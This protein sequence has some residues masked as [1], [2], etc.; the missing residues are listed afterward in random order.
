M[1]TKLDNQMEL[2]KERLKRRRQLS[3]SKKTLSRNSLSKNPRTSFTKKSSKTKTKEEGEQVSAGRLLK[4]ILEVK[5]EENE[6]LLKRSLLILKNQNQEI[7]KSSNQHITEKNMIYNPDHQANLISQSQQLDILL[8]SELIEEKDN[9]LGSLAGSHT[10]STFMGSENTINVGNQFLQNIE[11]GTKECITQ[12]ESNLDSSEMS[13]GDDEKDDF[14]ETFEQVHA[15]NSLGGDRS[16]NG[17]NIAYQYKTE[18]MNGEA[19]DQINNNLKKSGFKEFLDEQ[20]LSPKNVNF[21]ASDKSEGSD[22]ETPIQKEERSS[23]R[24]VTTDIQIED[25]PDDYLSEQRPVVDLLE[26]DVPLEEFGQEDNLMSAI[27]M[28]ES[29]MDNNFND[30]DGSDHSDETDLY[31]SDLSVEQNNLSNILKKDKV[32]VKT[33]TDLAEDSKLINPLNIKNKNLTSMFV[34]SNWN[35][36]AEEGKTFEEV[37]DENQIFISNI[38]QNQNALI[39]H[40]ITEPVIPGFGLTIINKNLQDSL[41]TYENLSKEKLLD[42]KETEEYKNNFLENNFQSEYSIGMSYDESEQV[43]KQI[44]EIEKQIEYSQHR[45]SQL[46]KDEVIFS[47]VEKEELSKNLDKDE[48]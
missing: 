42:P 29:I 45:L 41:T 46:Q 25:N 8:Q 30:D 10:P 19:E 24:F 47:N 7:M 21:L 16:H 1:Q 13:F 15:K 2:V 34:K 4:S 22:V 31:I 18:F 27:Q 48:Y 9:L 23:F 26:S 11:E 28:K 43:S 44:E 37:A 36:K 40:V 32:K 39:E 12:E 20:N 38:H 5:M 6:Q 35:T 17:F 3:M 33:L 14:I